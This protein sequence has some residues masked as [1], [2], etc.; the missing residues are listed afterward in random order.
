M[1]RRILIL[2]ASG[3]V[4]SNLAKK[5]SERPDVMPISAVRRVDAVVTGEQS[6]SVFLDLDRPETIAPALDGIDSIFLLTG[7]T[8]DMLRQ[9]KSL[10]DAA[11]KMSVKHIVHLGACGD[12]DTDVAHYGWHQ[13]VERYIEWSGIPFTHLRPEVFLENL[14]GYS[15]VRTVSDGVIRH[16]VGSARQV[17]VDVDDIAEVAAVVLSERDQHLGKTYRLGYELR[18]LHEI[19][20]I[21]SRVMGKP[22]RYEARP[23]EEFLRN[24]L[25]AGAEPA[26]MDCAYRSFIRL[27]TEGIPGS[28]EVFDNFEQ[29]TGRKPTSVEDFI[30]KHAAEFAY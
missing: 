1:D 30:R 21:M 22:Y 15:G 29:L 12:D 3:Q 2:G 23:P 10:I 13:F 11:R 9:S 14:L 7:Y 17:W 27:G 6:N 19:A 20:E 25:E 5:L 8:V 26:Y 24:V 4:G 16:Y 28:E 18:S